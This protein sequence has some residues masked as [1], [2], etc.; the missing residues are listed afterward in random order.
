MTAMV[1]LASQDPRLRGE[2]ARYLVDAGFE[3]QEF[4]QPPRPHGMWALIWLTER[5][6]HAR[7]AETVVGAWLGHG[8]VRR[9]VVVSWHPTALRALADRHRTH[10][11]VLPPPVFGWQVVDALR[12][13]D[14]REGG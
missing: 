7:V 4:D 11:V 14:G 5:E 8:R 9:V 13:D 6:L 1:A 2:L 10:L 3:V 12:A